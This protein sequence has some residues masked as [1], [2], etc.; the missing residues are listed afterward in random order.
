MDEKI[1]LKVN[2]KE[3]SMNQFVQNVFIK[4]I[5]GLLDTLDRVPVDRESIEIKIESPKN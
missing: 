1:A 3:I 4:V 2:G 5:K